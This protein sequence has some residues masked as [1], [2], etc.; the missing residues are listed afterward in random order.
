M[1]SERN[2]FADHVCSSLM[3]ESTSRT[4]VHPAL[5]KDMK[6]SGESE[7]K[8]KSYDPTTFMERKKRSSGTPFFEKN[9]D[10]SNTTR[11]DSHCHVQRPVRR[12]CSTCRHKN[13]DVPGNIVV[14]D[15][16]G[17]ADG[18]AQDVSSM[19]IDIGDCDWLCQHCGAMFWYGERLKGY[20][21]IRT[22]QYNKCCGGRN[23]VMQWERDLPAYI[24]HM[25]KDRHFLDNIWVYNQMFAITYFGA[26]IDESINKGRGPYV[27]KVS[28]Q[29]YHWIG[30]MY[31]PVGSAPQFLIGQ[32]R[33]TLVSPACEKISVTFD[34]FMHLSLPLQSTTTRKMSVTVF[35]CDRSVVRVTCTIRN[36]LIQRLLEDPL[37][38][39]SSKK[40]DDHL[41]AYKVP[42][43]MKN[44]KFL[45]LVHHQEE[46]LSAIAKK[47]PAFYGRTYK[48]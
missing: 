12:R 24:K 14:V 26:H 39:L 30:A 11:S 5:D 25:L 47:R 45:Q 7:R 34:P 27:F 4:N 23:I 32:Y 38:S 20:C 2:H 35:S 29:I 6:S 17:Q 18:I 8:R 15:S 10:S 44:T 42:M 31:P 13:Y 43:S 41:S 28:G 3:A 40:D 19:Y 9:V 33:S 21:N 16:S 37:M 46:L 48:L 36:H 1:G 22:P